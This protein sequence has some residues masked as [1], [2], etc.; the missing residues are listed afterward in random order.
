MTTLSATTPPPVMLQVGPPPNDHRGSWLPNRAMIAKR[1][2]ELGRRRGLMIALAVVTIGI[3]SIF[4]IVRLLAHG[5]DPKSYGPAG[6]YS[7]FTGLVSGV[8]YIFGFIVAAALGCTAGSVDL[9]EGVFRHLVVTGRSRV[10][11]YLARIPAGLAIIASLVAIGYAIVSLVCCLAAPSVLNY[12]G[13]NVPI[14]LSR[15]ALVSWAGDHYG[16]V[17]CNFSYE[18]KGPGPGGSGV[19]G[20]IP[21]GP[22]G[23]IDLSLLPSGVRHPTQ[24][25][26]RSE[27]RQVASEDYSDYHKQ[28][29]S[30]PIGLMVRAGLWIELE[31][32]IGFLVGL[33]LGSL[34]GQRTISV[35]LMIVLEVILTPI[36]LRAHIPY[37][38]NLQR[39]VV[40]VATD[41]LGPS[42]MPIAMGGG[43]PN[44]SLV[45]SETRLEA[46]IVVVA[47]ILVWTVLGAWRMATRD[48]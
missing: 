24:A 5:F 19:V 46:A 16:E 26:L 39:S 12:N 41:H 6:G 37:M 40:G 9:Q 45:I 38:L 48:A 47:W 43:G 23:T 35:I 7:I 34:I 1:F 20:P 29:L 32:A 13:V 18:I 17:L 33:G 44:Q 27:A 22:N 21:C 11:I 8:L 2:M 28:F 10:A 3:P 25:Q 36:F 42:A 15:P 31:A 14:G 30:P 4:L